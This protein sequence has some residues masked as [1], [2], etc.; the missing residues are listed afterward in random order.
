MHALSGS[1]LTL[2]GKAP[3]AQKDGGHEGQVSEVRASQ[4][5]GILGTDLDL[6]A[7]LLAAVTRNKCLNRSVS[8]FPHL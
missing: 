4:G 6:R 2:N 7:Q 5:L 3:Q 8:H 1:E